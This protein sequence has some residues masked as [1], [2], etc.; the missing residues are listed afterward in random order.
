MV[1]DLQLVASR[2]QKPG[3]NPWQS[4]SSA[5]ERQPIVDRALSDVSLT[6][7]SGRRSANSSLGLSHPGP[8]VTRG[9]HAECT[10]RC[11]V[12]VHSDGVR[13]FLHRVL[14][15]HFTLQPHGYFKR[16]LAKVFPR[17]AAKLFGYFFENDFVVFI[18]A[19]PGED[20]QIYR[21]GQKRTHTSLNKN[22][23]V[24]FSDNLGE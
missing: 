17:K 18:S 20:F 1:V 21:K 6:L 16:I 4:S 22:G 24:Y 11:R 12:Q 2:K 3:Q 23:T 15:T 14:D 19:G 9:P 5:S 13:R 8:A 7:P 10:R